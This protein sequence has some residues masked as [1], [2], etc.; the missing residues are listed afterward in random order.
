[1]YYVCHTHAHSHH[2][3]VRLKA[4]MKVQRTR[5]QYAAWL[6][7]TTSLVIVVDNNIYV[8]QSP[9]DEDDIR[10]TDTGKP[11]LIYN[12]VPDWLYQ[13]E[14]DLN[15]YRWVTKC[16]FFILDY[17]FKL[18]MWFRLNWKDLIIIRLYRFVQQKVIWNCINQSHWLILHFRLVIKLS[19]FNYCI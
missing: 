4:S 5:L 10:I 14:Y 19:Y 6:G 16:I 3:P 17:V 1:M 2:M 12:G 18:Q 15:S 8:K 13:G 7:N 11:D 9:S